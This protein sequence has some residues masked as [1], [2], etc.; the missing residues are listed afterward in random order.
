MRATRAL[1]TILLVEDDQTIRELAADMLAADGYRVLAASTAHE[2]ME[3]LARHPDVDLIFSDV[4]M[5]R[6]DGLGMVR[7]LRRKGIELPVLLTSGLHTPEADH[8]PAQTDFLPKPYR[9][10]ELLAALHRL[11]SGSV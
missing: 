9:R 2:A 10:S 6:C 1:A 5:P 8:L 11:Q 3:K 7:Q 4:Q